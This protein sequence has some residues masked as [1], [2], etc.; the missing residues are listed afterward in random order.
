MS[1]SRMTP[2][3]LRTRQKI[4]DAALSLFIEKGYDKAT[5]RQIA[6]LAGVAPGGIY[7]YFDGKEHIVQHFYD[8]IHEEH[9]RACVAI[10][11]Q[12]TKLEARLHA[13]VRLKIELAEP[14]KKVSGILF[15]VASDPNNPLSPFSAQSSPTRDKSL[16]QFRELVS[17]S[18]VRLPEDVEAILADYLWLYQMGIILYWIHDTSED[19][20][21]THRLIDKSVKLIQTLVNMSNLPLIAPLRKKFTK[22][23][24]EFLPEWGGHHEETGG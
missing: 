24:L 22:M 17:G 18:T 16:A 21:K 13:V 19:S 15:R 3:A 2:K 12:E 1:K 10:L 9:A 6:L 5:M 8:V 23:M 4:L 11:Q 7:H 14:F 20:R